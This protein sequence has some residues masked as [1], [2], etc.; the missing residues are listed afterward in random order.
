L[1]TQL[2]QHGERIAVRDALAERL[3]GTD[4]DISGNALEAVI[5]RLRRKLAS[6]GA[7]VRIEALRGIGYRLRRAGADPL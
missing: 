3:F 5:S 4:E 2:L 6:L 7:H 1:F